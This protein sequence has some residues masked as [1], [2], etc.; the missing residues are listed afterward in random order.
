MS[1]SGGDLRLT[2]IDA[3]PR[4][5]DGTPLDR[6]H[7]RREFQKITTGTGLGEHLTP[8]KLRHSFVSIPSASGVPIEDISDL[9][10]N[11]GTSVT[12][13]I[14][15]YTRSGPRSPWARRP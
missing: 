8:R 5:Q 1:W 14:Y 3:L 9:V 10:G 4:G 15:R 7:V 13:T 6:W 12:E 11:S 2:A